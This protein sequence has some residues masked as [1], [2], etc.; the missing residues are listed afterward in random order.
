MIQLVDF[1]EFWYAHHATR[2]TFEL[3]NLLN[4][5]MV[6][7]ASQKGHACSAGQEL[8]AFYGT[9]KFNAVFYRASLFESRTCFPFL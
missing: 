4:N 3:S 2:G 5:S 6:L 7:D 1:H 8:L 9:I